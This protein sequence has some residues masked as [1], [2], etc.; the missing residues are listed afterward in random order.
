MTG[1]TAATTW[2][3][4][5][6]MNTEKWP[7]TP[8]IAASQAVAAAVPPLA[9]A[10]GLASATAAGVTAVTAV[11]DAIAATAAAF[12]DTGDP[13]TAVA[14]ALGV[15]AVTLDTRVLVSDPDRRQLDAL[16]CH[17]AAAVLTTVL[18]RLGGHSTAAASH[19][20]AAAVWAWCAAELP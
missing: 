17:S 16:S 4:G 9:P 6:A 8:K 15:L 3:T 20:A 18:T 13:V 11:A 19:A 10:C 5:R 2:P 12:Y 1:G 14:D 7:E